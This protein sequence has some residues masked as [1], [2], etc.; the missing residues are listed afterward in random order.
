MLFRLIRFFA[1]LLEQLQSKS[2]TV[3]CLVT[4]KR[5]VQK[6]RYGTGKT[7]SEPAC[8]L[9][10]NMKLFVYYMWDNIFSTPVLQ[11]PRWSD[12]GNDSFCI[13]ISANLVEAHF[14]LFF[15]ATWKG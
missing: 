5:P 15:A 13:G 8:L 9:S 6:A 3:L 10:W 7:F 14:Q 2:S 4:K 12:L 1:Y 11:A